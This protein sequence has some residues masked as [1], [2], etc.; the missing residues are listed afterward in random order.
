[1]DEGTDTICA[2]V[3]KDGI[4]ALIVNQGEIK[5]IFYNENSADWN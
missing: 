5:N 1:M 2:D 4:Y 3:E